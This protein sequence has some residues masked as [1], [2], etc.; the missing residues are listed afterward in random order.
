MKIA[1][2]GAGHVG[3]N[4]GRALGSL[5]HDIVFGVP[6]PSKYSELM[7]EVSGVRD[8]VSPRQAGESA[9][10][11]FLAIPYDAI[12]DVI[13]DLGAVGDK[14]LVDCT[15]PIDQDD[16]PRRAETREKSGAETIASMSGGGRVVKAFNTAGASFIVDPSHDGAPIDQFICGDDEDAKR[17]VAELSREMG[18]EVVDCG[19]LHVAAD[20]EHLAA[21]W[22]RL[23]YT[24]KLGGDIAFKLLR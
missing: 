23:A 19:P 8:I 24:E 7:S 3:S 18:Y 16:G 12:G 1:I 10:I 9:E 14:I 2:V 20:L 17:V 22:I 4:L 13:P 21:L 11:I 5:G 6:D 15:N